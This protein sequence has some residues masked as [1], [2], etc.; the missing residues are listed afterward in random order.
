MVCG[1]ARERRVGR[2]NAVCKC[3]RPFVVSLLPD[4]HHSFGNPC[5]YR[6]PPG[7]LPFTAPDQV[8]S[9]LSLPLTHLD[10]SHLLLP[11]LSYLPFLPLQS[12]AVTFFYHPLVLRTPLP[13]F[14]QPCLSA[15]STTLGSA[16]VK[17]PHPRQSAIQGQVT[18]CSQFSTPHPLLNPLSR[19]FGRGEPT[20][21]PSLTPG[22]LRQ[23]HLPT[24]TTHY[25]VEVA[26]T[27]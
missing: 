2:G 19:L 5:R 17:D 4:C 8:V 22:P 25:L 3:P 11:L 21:W 14:K 20:T 16:Q 13:F 24:T 6:F 7:S 9:T 12:T 27:P 18:S 26:S 23:H 15:A 10:H 1:P